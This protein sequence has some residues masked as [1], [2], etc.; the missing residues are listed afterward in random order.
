MTPD[1]LRC[2]HSLLTFLHQLAD[3]Q[4]EVHSNQIAKLEL[5]KSA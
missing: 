4:D 1:N 2:L 5:G 3:G